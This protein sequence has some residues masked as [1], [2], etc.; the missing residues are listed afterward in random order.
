M[1]VSK[2]DPLKAVLY[3]EKGDKRPIVKDNY[4]LLW[5][6]NSLYQRNNSIIAIYF[7]ESKKLDR[8]WVDNWVLTRL[9][10][11]ML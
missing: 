3:P 8:K 1:I 9:G 4:I 2:I 5:K 10:N 11:C 7:K 6:A